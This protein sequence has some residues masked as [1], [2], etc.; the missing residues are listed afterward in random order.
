[1]IVPLI[2]L[3]AAMLL[4]GYVVVAYNRFVAQRTYIDSAWSS[5][6]VELTRRADLIPNLIETVRG[7]AAHEASVLAAVTDARAAA[8]AHRGDSPA[9][10]A[11][12]EDALSRAAFKVSAVAEAYPDL[13]A[14][15]NFLDLQRELANTEDRLA[16][17]RRLYN[18]NVRSYNERVASIPSNIV[19]SVFNFETRDFFEAAAEA[20]IV[21]TVT[22]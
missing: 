18:G 3:A 6:D 12:F 15:A 17:G 5:I 20:R 7:Y 22:F 21:P 4:C 10:R 13:K 2:A 11:P 16:T 8:V 1:M 14:S 9:E 19:A